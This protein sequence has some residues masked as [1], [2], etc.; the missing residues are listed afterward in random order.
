VYASLPNRVK[1]RRRLGRD[2]FATKE[3][4]RRLRW[5][6]VVGTVASVATWYL[7]PPH[8]ADRT[9]EEG[10]K[11][12]SGARSQPVLT[13]FAAAGGTRLHRSSNVWPP[14]SPTM[15][16]MSFS[17]LHWN[18]ILIPRNS[19]VNGAPKPWVMDSVYFPPD[20]V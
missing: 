10:S 5:P 2:A 15:C 19:W 18:E 17:R 16:H 11:F 8:R 1:R 3:P 14:I 12:L 20:T 6:W 13:Y 4:A 7:W 9:K